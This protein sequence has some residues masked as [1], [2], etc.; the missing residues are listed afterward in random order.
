M[1]QEK[2]YE[3]ESDDY[4]Q[5]AN[6]LFH[7]MKES[8]FLNDI[9]IKKA[10]IPRYCKEDIAYLKIKNNGIPFNEILVLQKCFCDIPFHK[11][12]E[13]LYLK[14][15]GENF[16]KCSPE[17]QNLLSH[18]N[19]HP[20]FYGYYGIAFPKSWGEKNN[21]QPVHYLNESS[22]YIH[23]FTHLIEQLLADN[24]IPDICSNDIIRRLTYIKPLRGK[25]T[26][27]IKYQ[28]KAEQTIDF[29]KNFHD[30]REWRYVP[31]PD[32]LTEE[33]KDPIIANPNYIKI[34]TD[35][36]NDFNFNTE[37]TKPYCKK[38]WLNYT[39][40]NIRYLIVPDSQARYDLINTILALPDENFSPNTDISMQKY[41]L[42]SKIL[43]LNELRKDW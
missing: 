37:L 23:D 31:D 32:S 11:L 35:T 39:Y 3:L 43:V 16:L 38:L 13:K 6:T 29:L 1:P 24:D 22:S 15:T 34:S 41:I 4:S 8:R 18:N 28:D 33:K 36:H 19:T 40:E 14:G 26:R 7:F 10:I 25:M 42:I 30:E 20:D 5:S 12:T 2:I 17:E 21:L 9:L 27:S